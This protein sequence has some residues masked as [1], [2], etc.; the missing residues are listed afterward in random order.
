[1]WYTTPMVKLLE[2]AIAKVSTLPEAAQ[3]KIGEEL[4]LHVAKVHRLRAEL[5]KGLRSLDHGEGHEIDI[6]HVIKRA[7]AQYGDA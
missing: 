3:E 4:L 5:D 1:M 2:K 6:E 7:R